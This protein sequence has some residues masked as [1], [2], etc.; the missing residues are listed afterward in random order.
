MDTKIVKEVRGK[1]YNQFNQEIIHCKLCNGLTTMLGTQRCDQCWELE[2][3]IHH[4]L[5]LATKIIT[6]ET[7]KRLFLLLNEGEHYSGIILG[8][9][10]APSHHLILLPG[11]SE[12]IN[13]ASALSWAKS[14]GGELPTRREQSLLYANLKEQFKA[15]WYWSSEQHAESADYAWVQY[16]GNGSQ[17]LNHKYDEWRARAVRREIIA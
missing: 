7:I 1:K 3:R 11:E 14:V 5:P 10:G 2:T 16:F 6:D 15:T 9:E 8:K 4:D 13:W 12:V 17:S